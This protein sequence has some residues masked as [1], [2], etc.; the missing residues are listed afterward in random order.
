MATAPLLSNCGNKFAGAA[1][2]LSTGRYNDLPGFVRN[3]GALEGSGRYLRPP[4]GI[5][6]GWRKE[7]LDVRLCR[8][9][10]AQ[11][12]AALRAAQR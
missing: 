1:H 10:L 7:G 12:F 9:S 8:Q 5:A 3:G 6:G 11:Q 2:D 4:H